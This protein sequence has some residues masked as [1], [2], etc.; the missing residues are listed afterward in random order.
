MVTCATSFTKY[1]TCTNMKKKTV[2]IVIYLPIFLE[3]L[4]RIRRAAGCTV[5]VHDV[6][7]AYGGR[8]GG[9]VYSGVGVHARPGC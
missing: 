9:R 1:E 4:P 3:P 2:C 5:A 7:N 6:G 8:G